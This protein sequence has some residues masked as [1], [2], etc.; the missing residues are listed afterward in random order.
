M[1]NVVAFARPT[2]T[3]EASLAFRKGY[4][5]AQ[6]FYIPALR[7]QVEDAW[8]K[9]MPFL[10]GGWHCPPEDPLHRLACL[11]A[12]RNGVRKA[13]KEVFPMRILFFGPQGSHYLRIGVYR[14]YVLLAAFSVLLWHSH[15]KDVRALRKAAR[16]VHAG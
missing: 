1:T 12:Y 10:M 15:W 8:V 6:E 7:E 4:E 5:A 13:L 11:P 2:A 9:D 16:T 14:S 3:N